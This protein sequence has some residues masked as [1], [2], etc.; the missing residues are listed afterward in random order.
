M[1][2]GTLIQE[3]ILQTIIA[4]LYSNKKFNTKFSKF[5]LTIGTILGSGFIIVASLNTPNLKSPGELSV[6]KENPSGLTITPSPFFN[7]LAV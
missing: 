5:T 4:T 1:M 3:T 6:F 2:P 7:E